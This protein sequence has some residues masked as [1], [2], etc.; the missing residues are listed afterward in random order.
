MAVSSLT[1]PEEILPG[2][3]E[4][5]S[6]TITAHAKEVETLLA[7]GAFTQVYFPA[8]LAKNAALA[9][10]TRAGDLPA[11]RRLRVSAAV[12]QIVLSAWMIDLYGDL[13]NKQKLTDAYQTFSGAIAELMAAYGPTR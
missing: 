10:E 11:D 8:M 7:Q 4:G 12:K 3:A 13:G 6:A 9:L 1:G 2:T 5:L